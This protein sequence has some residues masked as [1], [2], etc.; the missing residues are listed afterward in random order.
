MNDRT[1]TPPSTT[2]DRVDIVLPKGARLGPFEVQRLISRGASSFVYLATDH[3]LAMPVAL[4]EYLPMRLVYRDPWLHLHASDPTDEDI[5]NRGMQVFIEESRLL[6]RCEHPALMRV[7]HLF[8]AHGSAYRVMP[9]QPGRRLDDVR[10]QMAEPPPESALRALLDPLLG[11]LETIHQLDQVHGGV[12]A[13]NILLSDQDLPVLLAPGA[14]ARE[15]RSDLVESLMAT[16]ESQPGALLPEVAPTGPSIDLCALAEVMRF[17]ITGEAAVPGTRPHEP[18]SV[19]L[20]RGGGDAPMP[21]YSTEFISTLDAAT[22]S[23]PED[24]PTSVAQCRLWLT[25]GAPAARAAGRRT[26]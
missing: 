1:A 11:A 2:R 9:F 17:C 25:H 23:S 16:V 22:S 19:L 18:L 20:G 26:V 8:E 14:A 6:A 15:I 24:W 7:N 3:A 12:T 21:V 10:R 5:L 13:A 4:Q